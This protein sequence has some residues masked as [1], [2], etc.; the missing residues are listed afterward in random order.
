M[1]IIN[2]FSS[3]IRQTKDKTGAQHGS[4]TSEHSLNPNWLSGYFWRKRMTQRFLRPVIGCQGGGGEL[5]N[6]FVFMSLAIVTSR[7]E[8]RASLSSFRKWR[9]CHLQIQLFKLVFLLIQASK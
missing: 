1:F 5:A 9:R 4:R 2:H 6:L 8:K 7:R 3:K